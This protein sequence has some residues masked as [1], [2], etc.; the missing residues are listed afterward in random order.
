[1]SSC[2]V[3]SCQ[4]GLNHT[5]KLQEFLHMQWVCI[6]QEERVHVSVRLKTDCICM[7]T[8]EPNQEGPTDKHVPKVQRY[9]HNNPKMTATQCSSWPEAFR[10]LKITTHLSKHTSPIL[11]LTASYMKAHNL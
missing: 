8:W 10:A 6:V 3:C 5:M 4:L 7:H 2:M 11:A 9:C 1:M